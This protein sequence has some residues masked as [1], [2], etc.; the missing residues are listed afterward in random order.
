[1]TEPSEYEK[2]ANPPKQDESAG[3]AG[4]AEA[5]RQEIRARIARP[6]KGDVGRAE[7]NEEIFQGYKER[8]LR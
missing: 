1:M 6:H 5:L 3:R 4:R 8:E 7:T 2:P